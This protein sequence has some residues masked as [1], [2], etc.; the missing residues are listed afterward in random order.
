MSDAGRRLVSGQG[1]R[2]F[3]IHQ[4]KDRAAGFQ[5]KAEFVLRIQIVLDHAG[6]AGLAARGGNGVDRCP[7]APSGSAPA[8][9]WKIFQII[10]VYHAQRNGLGR[11]DDAAAAHCQEEVRTLLP[12]ACSRPF[13]TRDRRGLGCTPPRLN[14]GMPASLSSATTISSQAGT[15]YAPPYTSITLVPPVLFYLFGN[16]LFQPLCQRQCRYTCGTGNFPSKTP[17]LMIYC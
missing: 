12:F 17:L 13:F 14:K 1:Y 7:Q 6:T 9:F 4:R 10:P 5:H 15:L 3:G 8:F 11:I 2:P 16:L